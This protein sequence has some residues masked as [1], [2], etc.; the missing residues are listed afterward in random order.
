M[1]VCVEIIREASRSYYYSLNYNSIYVSNR[2]SSGSFTFYAS[3]GKDYIKHKL[4]GLMM[5]ANELEIEFN[6]ES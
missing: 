3:E 1:R 5:K 6:D 2:D 4:S